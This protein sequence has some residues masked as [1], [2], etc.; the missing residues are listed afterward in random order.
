MKRY[1]DNIERSQNGCGDVTHRALL[2]RPVMLKL[3]RR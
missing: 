2:K 3:G 1:R